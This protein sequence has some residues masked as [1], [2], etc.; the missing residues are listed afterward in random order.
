MSDPKH[1]AWRL[2][3]ME[4]DTEERRQY[5]LDAAGRSESA[6]RF[7]VE[8]L[9]ETLSTM[10]GLVHGHEFTE[11]VRDVLTMRAELAEVLER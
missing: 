1:A 5:V 6:G 9:L 10:D 11:Q 2:A 3:A 8:V 7:I 4:C